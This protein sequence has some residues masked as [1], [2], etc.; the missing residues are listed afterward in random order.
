[1]VARKIRETACRETDSVHPAEFECVT[2]D[3]HH[4]GVD[5]AF[6]HH[7]EQGL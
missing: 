3:F 5:A 7:R 2:G 6:G 1:M 4:R